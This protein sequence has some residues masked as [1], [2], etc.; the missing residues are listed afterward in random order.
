MIRH[1][2][3][4]WASSRINATLLLAES[5]EARMV[6][7]AHDAG[8]FETGGILVGVFRDGQPC[9][10]FALE[11]PSAVSSRNRYEVPAGVTQ[12]LVG[13]VQRA[14]PRLGYLGEWHVHTV[15]APPS[16]VDASTMVQISKSLARE[17]TSP[18]LLVLR[19]VSEANFAI[20]ASRWGRSG[21]SPLRVVRSGDL[22]LPVKLGELTADP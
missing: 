9:V 6:A 19:R 17:K 8:G 4:E 20:D 21:R 14:D 18:I 12:S 2:L 13:C 11:I 15:D 3:P 10:A 16:S 5:A 7:A 1:V 22:P